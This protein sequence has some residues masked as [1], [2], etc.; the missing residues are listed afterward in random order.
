MLN[1][2]QL[3]RES[4]K[5]PNDLIFN[6]QHKGQ[7]SEQSRVTL[8]NPALMFLLEFNIFI[9]VFCQTSMFSPL[10]PLT[11]GNCLNFFVGIRQ[12]F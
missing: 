12:H 4:L 5:F 6:N 7:E 1:N 11:S 3:K 8:S 10:R 9:L 2:S